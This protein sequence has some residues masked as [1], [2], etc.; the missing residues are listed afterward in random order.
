MK[1]ELV[2]IEKPNT[3]NNLSAVWECHPFS[4]LGQG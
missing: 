2:V 1:L 3:P 4:K